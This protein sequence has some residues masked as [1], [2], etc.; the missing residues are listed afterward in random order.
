M[1]PILSRNGPS[2]KLG[3]VQISWGWNIGT[4]ARRI[5][6]KSLRGV[7]THCDFADVES[8]V[9][10]GGGLEHLALALLER[11]PDLKG[12]VLDVPELIPLAQK[13]AATAPAHVT[14]RL[15][16]Q[17]GDMLDDVPPGQVYVL[18]HIIHD[19]DD[20]R[21]M[22]LL[23][24]CHARMKGPGRLIC[25]DAVLPP[26]GD[27]GSTPAKLLDIDMMV[28]IPGKERTEVQ[29]KALY[30]AAGFEITS[31]AP[32]QDNFGTSVIQG[33]QA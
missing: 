19:W 2:G 16:F 13:H 9:D 8:V 17:G 29:W 18:K 23:K 32:L 24:N 11:Y 7:L 10:V 28:F 14:S 12:Q 4:T 6:L 31:I 26:M 20:A 15:T 21:C 27:V 1:D 22:Q 33:T 5:R 30:R 25:V 3:T